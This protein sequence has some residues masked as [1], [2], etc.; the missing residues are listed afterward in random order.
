MY[1]SRNRDGWLIDVWAQPGAKK[2]EIVGEY[3]G[4][5]KI[6]LSA[7]AVDNKANRTLLAFVAKA[8]KVKKSQ[9]VLESG[10]SNRRKRLAVNNAADPDFTVLM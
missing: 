10:H 5:V 6:R 8:L 7:P 4:C 2:T 1:V 9:V 3:Q